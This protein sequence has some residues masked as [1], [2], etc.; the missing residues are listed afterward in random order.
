MLLLE[1]ISEFLAAISIKITIRTLQNTTCSTMSWCIF[2]SVIPATFKT[3]NSF[4]SI[5][6]RHLNSNEKLNGRF[7]MYQ[8]FRYGEL[9][10]LKKWTKVNKNSKLINQ[11]FLT[12]KKIRMNMLFSLAEIKII[13]SNH[14]IFKSINQSESSI[15]YK[16]T[17]SFLISTNQNWASIVM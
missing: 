15:N 4:V 16:E 17:L 2:V 1:M 10:S 7:K 11:L 14:G 6:W 3:C 12:R 5:E 13:Q 8:I 9:N